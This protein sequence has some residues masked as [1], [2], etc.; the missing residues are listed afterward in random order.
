MVCL[1]NSFHMFKG[2]LSMW[3]HIV[4]YEQIV[5]IFKQNLRKFMNLTEITDIMDCDQKDIVVYA[6]LVGLE[7][8]I[9]LK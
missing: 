3:K 7:I 2:I 9:F 5:S 1:Q 8:C 6:I 4:V